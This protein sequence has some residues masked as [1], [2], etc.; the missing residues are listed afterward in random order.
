SYRLICFGSRTWR[1]PM[2]TPTAL[3]VA[4]DETM[5]EAVKDITS[6]IDNL[7]LE[8]CGTIVQAQEKLQRKEAAITLVH[9][10]GD[11]EQV[12]EFLWAMNKSKPNWPTLVL[13]NE[14]RN[15]QAVTM[16]RA[17]ATDYFGLPQ[18]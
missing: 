4:H 1:K 3:L 15:H 14:Y 18:D 12:T 6:S 11:E 9:V 10:N 16:L 13:S 17:G 7:Q 2:P 5:R 8:T